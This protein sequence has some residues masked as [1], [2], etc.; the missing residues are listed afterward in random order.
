MWA[1]TEEDRQVVIKRLVI[2]ALPAI[3]QRHACDSDWLLR[4]LARAGYTAPHAQGS[5]F[6]PVRRPRPGTGR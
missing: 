4:Q 6:E 5:G 1:A 3:A 2:A